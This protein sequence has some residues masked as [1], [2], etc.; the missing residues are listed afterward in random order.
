MGHIICATSPRSVRGAATVDKID[1]RQDR[2]D[3]STKGIDRT[4]ISSSVSPT[5]YGGK[6]LTAL[7]IP[8]DRFLRCSVRSFAET[9]RDHVPRSQRKRQTSDR[10][11]KIEALWNI[12]NVRGAPPSCRKPALIPTHG[13]SYR[14]GTHLRGGGRK[15]F[16][17]SADFWCA[18]QIGEISEVCGSRKGL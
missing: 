4:Q 15:K 12:D 9:M 5:G 8:P 16:A 1:C 10:G 18:W 7:S 2:Y 3:L 11:L 13:S 6:R 17:H 14:Q